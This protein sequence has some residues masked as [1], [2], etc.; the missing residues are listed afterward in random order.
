MRKPKCNMPGARK[1]LF[2]AF[3]TGVASF[4]FVFA[5]ASAVFSSSRAIEARAEGEETSF[6][7]DPSEKITTSSELTCSV[8]SASRTGSTE[9]VG[10]RFG[11]KLIEAFPNGTMRSDVFVV[12]TDPNFNL[13]KVTAECDEAKKKAEEAGETYV[14]LEFDAAVYRI[15]RK[16]QS[17]INIPSI[18]KYGTRFVMN[19]T[20]IYANACCDN[21]GIAHYEKIEE[22]VIPKTITT[23]EAGAFYEA[24]EN[25]KFL[26]EA[27]QSY[28]DEEGATIVTYP[29]DWTNATPT[30]E[31]VLDED[32]EDA[33][34]VS[35]TI[36]SK[37]GI[38]AD[39]IIGY[40]SEDYDYPAYMEYKLDKKNGDSW[41]EENTVRYIKLPIVSTNNPYNAVG[42]KIGLTE[43][44]PYVNVPIST[45]TRVNLGSIVVHNI[46]GALQEQTPEG[47]Y[48]GRFIPDIAKG[49]RKAVPVNM[50]SFVPT[51]D[52]Y[53]DA[54]PLSFATF[55]R[56][57]EFRSHFVRQKGDTGYGV[58]PSLAPLAFSAQ[59][60]NI[61]KGIVQIRY[62]FANLNQTSYIFHLKDGRQITERIATPINYF[63]VGEVED[64]SFLCDLSKF[65][66]AL[67][68]IVKVELANFT[69]KADLY[70]K[71]KNSIIVKSES[72]IRFAN[73]AI[74]PE[75]ATLP[76]SDLGV[77]FGIVYAC[78]VA[79]FAL[80][81]VAYY[82]YAKR[83]FRNDE[84]RR[85][86]KKKYV[87]A[88]IKNFIG[89][90]FVLSAI[91]FIVGRWGLFPTSVVTF[92]PMD[93]FVIVF[94]IIALIFIGFTIKNFVV[95]IKNAR[96]RAEAARL[97]LDEDV[98]DD[99]TH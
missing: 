89:F 45:D 22:I 34:I 28:K 53:F 50:V 96:K 84:F 40:E 41:V 30:Y 38:G 1:G 25:I 43:S 77:V 29:E 19:V 59:K 20:T 62:Q 11:S 67:P 74:V 92:N 91:L 98:D 66:F 75:A 73:L 26:C 94:T 27:P 72:A 55:G 42:T 10:V 31:Y 5:A 90:A 65:D 17:H 64:V 48:T 14:P 12:P 6:I 87:V 36:P 82:F 78:Y 61:D 9:A 16:N 47:K 18:V 39:F 24:P 97:R 32:D 60:A 46:Y 76:H 49:P 95:S 8:V 85:M 71:D 70:N 52:Q 37:F 80:L 63:H 68:D 4:A 58:Y 51:F 93:P 54:K 83:R 3:V 86:N 81:A 44:I 33:L 21:N 35:T 13:D 79:G 23:I 99:G 56:Y 69:I 2:R 88:A 15:V 7:P 57:F